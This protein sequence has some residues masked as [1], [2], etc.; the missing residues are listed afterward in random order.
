MVQF[1]GF[2]PAHREIRAFGERFDPLSRRS[3]TGHESTD[4]G[5]PFPS[6]RGIMKTKPGWAVALLAVTF[7]LAGCSSGTPAAGPEESP[8]VEEESP[9]PTPTPDAASV[10][11]MIADSPLG[12]IIVDGEGMTAYYFDKD[13]PDSGESTCAGDCA[14]AWPSIT[15]ESDTP[16]V[17]GVT[18]EVGT[19]VGIAGETHITIN[20]MPIYTFAKD[21]APGDING[22]GAN[23]VWW[24]VAPDGT[25]I[26]E[27]APE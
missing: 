23:E 21:A 26:T 19:I 18:A 13:V 27:L 9:T 24:V 8:T 7:A 15:A 6:E 14:T 17:E 25:K 16:S 12:D 1:G 2:R 22:Q 3:G 4:S 5:M 10:D 11:L 20:G